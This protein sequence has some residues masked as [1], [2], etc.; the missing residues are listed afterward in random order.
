MLQRIQTIYLLIAV[1]LS[2]LCL[3]MQIGTFCIDGLTVAR[4]YNLWVL[5][6]DNGATH[7][8]SFTTAPMFVVL[9]LS[10]ALGAYS[11]FAY[12]NRLVQA[13]FCM[14]N[15]LLLVGWYMLYAV[16]R[17][18]L[19]GGDGRAV[20]FSLSFAAFFPAVALVF[21]LLARRSIMADERLVRAADRL[22]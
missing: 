10:A 17:H 8:F 21:Y 6:V 22:R 2:V 11:V 13:R 18:V 12:R 15:M 1:V 3:C 4:E 5:H 16:Y 19:I 20:D 7:H 14:F 9:L